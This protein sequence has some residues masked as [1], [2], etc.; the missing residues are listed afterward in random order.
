MEKALNILIIEDSRADF[1]LIERHLRQQGLSVR[2]SRVD[3]LEELKDNLEKSAWNLVLSD[4]NVQKLDFSES[5]NFIRSHYPEMPVILVSGNIGEEQAV[6]LLKMGVEDFILKDNLSR[7]APAVER[8]LKKLENTRAWLA[9]EA[10]M[11]ASEYRFRSIF[12][13]SPIAIG[14]GHRDDGK[15]VEVNSAWLQLY[16]FERDEVIGR[17]IAELN[18]YVRD[19]ERNEVIRVINECGHILNHEIHLRK[20]S[21]D[22]ILVQYSAE[23]IQ[24]GEKAFLQTMTTDI[25]ERKHME[26]ELRKSEE[27][28][29]S[30]FANM[31]NGFAYC[32]L[33]FDSGIPQ[34]FI[35]LSVNEAFEKQTGLKDVVGKKVT[36]VIPGIRETDPGIFEVYARVAMTGKPE[37]LEVYVEALEE[38][39]WISVYSPAKEHFIAVFDVI[40]ERKRIET[41]REATLELLQICNLANNLQ[42]LMQ[43]LMSFF[44]KI[45]GCEA[46]GV[47][48]RDGEDFPYYVT[49]GFDEE[50]V[51]AEN[52]L[53]SYD[54]K[55]DV[56]RD[57]CGHP[58]I[59][60]M[61]GNILCGRFDASKP[62][63]TPRGSFWSSCTSEL[64]AT[65]TDADRQA[66]TRNRCNGE[67][68]ESVALVPLRYHNEIF[69]LFQFN[70]RKKGKFTQEKVAQLEELVAYVA[71]AFSKLK[72]DEALRESEQFSM[73]IINN[74]EEGIVVY[75]ANLRFRGWNPY[76]ERLSGLTAREVIGKKPLELFPFLKDEGGTERLKRILEG[77]SI[78]SLEFPFHFSFNGYAGWISETLSPLKNAKGEIT[79]VIGVMR[80]ITARKQTEDTL[81]KL[82]AAV[83][84]SPTIV[85]ITD[86]NG[87]I[88]F[89]NPRFT[90]LTGFSF[91]EAIGR[92]PRIQK[93][94]TPHEV[95][96]DL[97]ETITTG[98]VWE[99][100]LRNKR[101]DGSL[102]WEHA[103][104]SP[105]RDESGEITHYLAIKEDITERRNLEAQLRQSQK[106]EAIG[107]LAGGIAHDFNNILTAIV[108]YSTLLRMDKK[109]DNKSREY[110]N[111]LLGL[112]ERASHLTKGLL[113]FSRKQVMKP[114]QVN[115]NDIVITIIKLISRL[116]GESIAVETKLTASP[117]PIM[118]DC[119][120]IEQVLMNL[121]TNARDAMPS[122]GTLSIATDMA[123]L[124]PENQLLTNS[125][126]PGN[127]A[128]I[129]V[130]DTGCGM[131]EATM[132]RIFEPF[133]TTKGPEK[134]TGLGLSI[135]YGII[136]QHHGLVTVTSTPGTGTTFTILLPLTGMV[137]SG[138]SPTVS[139][140]LPGV[141]TVM[142]VEDDPSIRLVLSDVLR[143]FGYRVVEAPDGER[144][145][146]IF[147]K[148]AG[149]ISLVILDI[150][151]PRK[152]GRE[153]YEAML[154][155]KHDIHTLFISGY[156]TD[157][158]TQSE[159]LPPGAQFLQKPVSPMELLGS[160][161]KILDGQPSEDAE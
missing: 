92:N 102:F 101:K 147:R 39:F 26:M 5:F 8:S 28:Y 81:R 64:L 49:H 94:D 44:Q 133:F 160:V 93:G 62:F 14:I 123:I 33:L 42:D 18:L 34:D 66:K 11:Q 143:Q 24:L 59:D 1:L 139:A 67:G 130:G 154:K 10:S 6:E 15:L 43:A 122:G 17:T 127:Y 89:V 110:A 55:G 149:E 4:Y 35:Y 134:G 98:K 83:E 7:L 95:F 36:E 61:C 87:I 31:L 60:C 75:D 27:M 50:F 105:I 20:K 79:G 71:I 116:I 3:S 153:T 63:F 90:Q 38:W 140:P 21:G 68:Y 138:G 119:G 145:L 37:Q 96:Q 137:G 109:L 157:V 135:L 117:L 113:A 30:L 91:E 16:G 57:H 47:R 86:K 126:Q 97:W 148:N 78:S 111:N 51:L 158:I 103:T 150:I 151:M 156:P 142:L 84:Q 131:D 72:S 45:T 9:G 129:S 120:Q 128:L 77:R 112:V 155:I 141:E 104:I 159:F 13:S 23:I 70:D 19:E 125:S 12:N 82:Y 22:I 32:R 73:Q 2:C 46:I 48:L 115:L 100:D 114:K 118:A 40:T 74:A 106:L 54:Q 144:A 29:R 69:G 41:A 58:A 124:E 85:M 56:I 132:A 88:E 25:T 65:T 52:F 80:D 146:E 99:G 161:R 136:K 152:N 76:M 53:C 107:T 108:G 121:A